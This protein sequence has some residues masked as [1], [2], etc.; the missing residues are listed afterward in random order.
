MLIFKSLN[1]PKSRSYIIILQSGKKQNGKSLAKISNDALKAAFDGVNL[2][3]DQQALVD[4]VVNTIN[5]NKVHTLEYA[6]KEGYC[7]GRCYESI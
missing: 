2:S 5:S 3:E 1:V 7:V 6:D 4:I